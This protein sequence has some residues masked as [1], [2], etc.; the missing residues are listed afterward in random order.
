MALGGNVGIASGAARSLD[1]NRARR[2]AAKQKP[3]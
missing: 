3:G 1:A 2:A